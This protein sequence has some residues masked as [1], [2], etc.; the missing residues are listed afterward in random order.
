[1]QSELIRTSQ[2]VFSFEVYQDHTCHMH[3]LGS[4]HRRGG[5]GATEALPQAAAAL[6]GKLPLQ[7]Q[8]S[9]TAQETS[10]RT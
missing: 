3:A 9:P 7:K 10:S 6:V 4:G 2:T 5:R 8:N 1:M